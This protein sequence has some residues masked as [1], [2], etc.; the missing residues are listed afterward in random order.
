M[1][2]KPA[3]KSHDETEPMSTCAGQARALPSFPGARRSRP[4]AFRSATVRNRPVATGAPGEPT[5]GIGALRPQ[6]AGSAQEPAGR[7]PWWCVRRHRQREAAP[8]HRRARL[9][10][11]RVTF[12]QARHGPLR[13]A[14][15][16]TF[17]KVA[18]GSP[19]AHVATHV[20]T[21]ARNRPLDRSRVRTVLVDGRGR[22]VGDGQQR[23]SWFS[24]PADPRRAGVR[25][26]GSLTTVLITAVRH[27]QVRNRARDRAFA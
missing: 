23:G 1:R 25:H 26:V 4:R 15:G 21:V 10:G 16:G 5:R 20:G 7:W 9:D 27:P 3:S 6:H 22:W 17:E 24:R 19:Y 18:V 12:S 11:M 13:L 8:R 2:R 14:A